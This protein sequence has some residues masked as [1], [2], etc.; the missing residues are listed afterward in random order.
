MVYRAAKP[1]GAAERAYRQSLAIEVQQ[2][3]RDG[4][5]SS[6][7]ELG[8]LY[9]D[10]ERWEEAAT[11]FLQAA[12]LYVSRHDLN[13]EGLVRNNLALVLIKLQHYDDARV[14]LQRALECKNRFGHAARP[15]RTWNIL[16]D[17][18]LTVGNPGAADEARQQAVDSYLA[19]RRDGG[20]PQ[21]RGGQLCELVAHAIRQG[22]KAT[23]E[24]ALSRCEGADAPPSRKVLLAKLHVILK[25]DRNPALASD[26]DLYYADAA[27][28]QLLLERLKRTG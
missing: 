27:E 12:D 1:F 13:R 9:K 15:W 14:E 11:F 19:Y 26:P 17:L 23:A 5:A 7:G 25:G 16:H 8:N 6:L 22:E 3:D 28:L 18:E 21:A 20:E 24:Q 4:E 10:M 2:H